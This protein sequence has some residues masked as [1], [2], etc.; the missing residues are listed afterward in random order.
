MLKIRR[1]HDRLIFNMGIAIPGKDGLYIETGPRSVS[2]C[3][4]ECARVECFNVPSLTSYTLS[5]C[6]Q[7]D[8]IVYSISYKESAKNYIVIIMS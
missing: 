6:L 1:S 4:V 5:E 7:S 8:T 3:D 2:T